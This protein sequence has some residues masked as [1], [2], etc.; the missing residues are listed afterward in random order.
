MSA[1]ERTDKVE[2]ARY[3]LIVARDQ[4]DLCDY[5]MRDFAADEEVQVLLDRRQGERRQHRRP[6]EPERR[7]ADRRQ[8]GVD[9]DLRSRSF[10]IIHR[11]P[12]AFSPVSP[13]RS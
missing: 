6:H 11:R 8:R 1:A 13:L 2:A 5:L 7:R 10:V 4:P 9:K 3:L 12:R